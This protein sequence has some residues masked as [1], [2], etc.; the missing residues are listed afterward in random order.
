MTTPI[1]IRGWEHG[2]ATLTINGGGL[3]AVVNTSAGATISVQ[4][5]IKRTGTYA[6]KLDKATASNCNTAKA[7]STPAVVVGSLYI[8]FS[9]FPASNN[10]DICFCYVTAGVTL[11]LKLDIA[12][13]K[14]Y[15]RFW[16]AADGNKANVVLAVDTWYR[17]DYKFNVSANPSTIDFQ[18][19]GTAAAQSTYAQA[20]TTITQVGI[21]STNA[22]TSTMYVDDEIY[23]ATSGDYPIGA[24]AVVGL[25]PS[26]DGTHNNASNIM[27]DIDGNDIDG[28][29]YYAYD[30][31]DENPWTSGAASDYV[32]QTG[33]GTG[34]YCEIQFAD[35]TEATIQGV[36]ALLEYASATA[37]G[38]TGGCII[39]S[40][41]TETTLWGAAGALADYSEASAFYKSVIVSPDGGSWTMAVVNAL[42][43]RF[44]YSDDANPDPY[45]LAIMLEV[46][47]VPA[48]GITLTV[49]DVA[50]ANALDAAG[51]IPQ[52]HN[53]HLVDITHANALDAV[54][55]VQQHNL[56]GI[57]D[58][59]HAHSLDAVVLARIYNLAVTDIAHG[60]VLDVVVLSQ[61]NLLI[62]A[63]I[64]HVHA[65][66]AVMLNQVHNLV[67]AD[68][69]HAHALDA[70]NLS[71]AI[72]LILAD[73]AH[74]NVLDAVVLSQANNLVVADIAHGHSLDAAGALSQVHNLT[75]ADIAHAHALEAL[76]LGYIVEGTLVVQDIVHAHAL[77]SL[78]L[79]QSHNLALADIAHGHALEAVVITR[80]YNLAVAEI[81]HGHALEALVLVSGIYL[82]V[83]DIAHTHTLDAM[84]LTQAHNLALADITHAHSLDALVISLG[85][86]IE[87][88]LADIIHTHSLDAITLADL[89]VLA[90]RIY[91]IARED[92]AWAIAGEDR[93]WAIVED[94]RNYGVPK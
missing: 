28:S 93:E 46:A 24:H 58:I 71:G 72:L 68:I 39:R 86:P 70:L 5:V 50:H 45:W 18:V 29:T 21:G 20:A 67:M 84:A 37:T 82:A 27:E 56:A 61:I 81:S 48:T 31:L 7:V 77:D 63:D 53:I 87:L 78:A 4:S 47:Y 65:L 15:A 92:R 22:N 80:I 88:V 40:N 1:L 79:I 90:A 54:A 35:T 43:C 23:S 74:A 30:K 69:A 36:M 10:D 51:A 12:D 83:A 60:H 19:N 25:R 85:V 11:G 76:V 75:L 2:L 16:G 57:A 13:K 26:A 38:N 32:R 44:G 42:R 8:Y 52:T 9:A 3:A 41:T 49:A 89:I 73:I 59:A 66:D 6:I 91:A 17:I 64:A 34:N 55:L 62:V 33:N 14:I 94:D